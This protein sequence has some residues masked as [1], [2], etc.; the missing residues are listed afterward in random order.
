LEVP[1][2]F[3]R[4]LVPGEIRKPRVELERF[5]KPLMAQN[6]FHQ[7]EGSGNNPSFKVRIFHLLESGARM[8]RIEPG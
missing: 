7:K 3:G 4:N 1:G 5:T 6:G 8:V 2:N